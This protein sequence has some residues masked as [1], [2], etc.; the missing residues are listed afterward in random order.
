MALQP[1]A[2]LKDFQLVDSDQ[3]CRGWTVRDAAGQQVGTV[4]DMLVDTECRG[5]CANRAV[6][7]DLKPAAAQV[8]GHASLSVDQ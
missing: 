6:A 2:E 8:Q 7:D 5:R 3:D 4:R 1:L